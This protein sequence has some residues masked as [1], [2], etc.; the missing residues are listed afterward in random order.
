SGFVNKPDETFRKLKY[1]IRKIIDKNPGTAAIAVSAHPHFIEV[2]T[3]RY[4]VFLEQM[5]DIHD[6]ELLL[7]GD[8][9]LHVEDFQL[10]PIKA[11]SREALRMQRARIEERE[12]ILPPVEQLTEIVETLVQEVHGE[13]EATPAA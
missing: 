9:D 8:H 1:D 13:P 3:T 10:T 12:R 5:E 4:R 7:R 11:G 2:L 6:C